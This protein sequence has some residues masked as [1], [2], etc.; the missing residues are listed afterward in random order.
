VGRRQQA[1][2][3]LPQGVI[4]LAKQPLAF[5][6]GLEPLG[7]LTLKNAR[8]IDDQLVQLRQLAHALLQL[9]AGSRQGRGQLRGWGLGRARG[10]RDPWRW[11]LPGEWLLRGEW[12][13]RGGWLLQGTGGQEQS[14]SLPG[15]GPFGA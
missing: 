11:L 8:Q 12:L 1:L 2:Q 6:Q 3:V 15:P 13:V 5:E 10:A 9:L 14:Q 7:E 4:V